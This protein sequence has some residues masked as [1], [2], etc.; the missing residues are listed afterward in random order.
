[1][2][3]KVMIIGHLGKDPVIKYTET[4]SAVTT[5][6]V[7]MDASFTDRDGNRQ[8]KTEWIRVVTFSKCAE[9]CSRYLHKGS[10]VFVEGSLQT[11]SWESQGVKQ[12]I[13]EI[14]GQRVTFLDSRR[15]DDSQSGF[16]RSSFDQQEQGQYNNDY[17]AESDYDKSGHG[18]F[19][20]EKSAAS[21]SR[22]EYGPMEM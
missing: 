8:E 12:S 20:N 6:S 22:D 5:F 13:T 16:S 15:Y 18:H 10:L 17:G 2:L 9:N 3:N 4:G 11:R 7:A 14:R 21:S 19:M 1:M